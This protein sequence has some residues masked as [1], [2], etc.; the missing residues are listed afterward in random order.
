M[1]SP[2]LVEI[3]KATPIA[4]PTTIRTAIGITSRTTMTLADMPCV[5]LGCKLF[6]LLF[7]SSG[8]IPMSVEITNATVESLGKLWSGSSET[9]Y[10]DG[11][12]FRVTVDHDAWHGAPWE[13]EDGHGVVSG[14]VRRDKRPGERILCQDGSS[15]R[16][17]DFAET[18]RIARRDGWGISQAEIDKLEAPATLHGVTSPVRK[19]TRKQITALAV[20]RDFQRLRAWCKDDWHYVAVSV[21]ELNLSCP[22]CSQS[23]QDVRTESLCGIESD[24]YAYLAETALEL[25]REIIAQYPAF[26]DTLGMEWCVKSSWR[27]SGDY[28]EWYE[29]KEEAEAAYQKDK[30]KGGFTD[31]QL[32]HLVRQAP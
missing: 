15:K 31:L 2:A 19:L 6:S 18:M 5:T 29:T 28:E 13:E 4:R 21:C 25:A 9:F 24:S 32:L 22:C 11:R 10:L 20:E 7:F 3:E 17:Y 16:F 30:E 27:D 26:A 8:V 12:T 23:L 14:W 1:D